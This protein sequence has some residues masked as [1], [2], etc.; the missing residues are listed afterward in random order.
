MV[1]K[2]RE[3]NFNFDYFQKKQILSHKS[4]LWSH[5]KWGAAWRLGRRIGVNRTRRYTR[6]ISQMSELIGIPWRWR[7]LSSIRVDQVTGHAYGC[8][9]RLRNYGRLRWNYIRIFQ[10]RRHRCDRLIAAYVVAAAT[11]NWS[12]DGI[13]GSGLQNLFELSF[14][15]G[16]WRDWI[17]EYVFIR[18]H[19]RLILVLLGWWRSFT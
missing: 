2:I 1:W 17:I 5:F 10:R 14:K 9:L 18:R 12:L 13:R 11:L 4:E 3:L 6:R 8:S 7:C 16:R 15:W 19:W